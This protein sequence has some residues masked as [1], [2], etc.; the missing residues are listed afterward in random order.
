MD[1]LNTE[2]KKK[3]RNVKTD[4]DYRGEKTYRR[5]SRKLLPQNTKIKLNNI[6][7]KA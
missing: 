3:K 7:M 2:N 6:Y 5:L 4:Q 1:N